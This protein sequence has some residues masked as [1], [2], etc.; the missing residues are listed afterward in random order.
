M[1]KS[2][3]LIL[4]T[5]EAEF[6]DNPAISNKGKVPATLF[7]TLPTSPNI[8]LMLLMVFKRSVKSASNKAEKP[9]ALTNSN[10]NKL[11]SNWIKEAMRI[12]S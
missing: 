5:N 10:V 9:E 2:P 12:S 6:A 11:I 8:T 7:Q 3:S 4:S 1:P